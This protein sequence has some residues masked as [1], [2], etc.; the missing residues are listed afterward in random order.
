MSTI[1]R[2]RLVRGIL[3]CG[4]AAAAGL[5]LT[6]GPTGRCP[7]TS[8]SQA[9]RRIGSRRLRSSSSIRPVAVRGDGAGFAGAIE[10]VASA[11]GAG[12]KPQGADGYF[13][14]ARSWRNKSPMLSIAM[15]TDAVSEGVA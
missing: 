11:A 8:A 2:R 13:S 4:A 15:L 14:A 7:S 5:A 10:A 3:F 12:Y 9:V 6:A 1:D